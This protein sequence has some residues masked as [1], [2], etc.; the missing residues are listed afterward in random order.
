M[1]TCK[2]LVKD[3]DGAQR[4]SHPYGLATG[5]DGKLWVADAG[6]N[7]LLRVSPG[8]GIVEWIAAFDAMPG[9]FPNPNRGGEM[10]TDAVPTGVAFDDEGNAYVSLL[11]GAPFIPGSA[12]VVK[13]TPTGGKSDFA[14]GLTMLTDIRR[15][16]DGN[17]YAVQ[18][19]VFTDQGP[20]PNSGA[21]IQIQEGEGSA[22]VVEG[23]SFPT[24]IGFNEAGD[25]FVTT[26]GVGAPGSGQ[27]VKFAVLTAGDMAES[28]EAMES[29]GDMAAP[30]Q[31]PATGAGLPAAGALAAVL[32]TLGTAGVSVL[33]TRRRMN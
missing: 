3:P 12:K 5:P 21:I 25:A 19:G 30:E 27:V 32:M 31:L 18:F 22:P 17:F 23:L 4:H 15:A 20:T 8:A 14:T 13:V 24:S 33:F 11:S 2:E 10:L 6:G 1:A 7:R 28:E 26:N 16:P 29:E 9:V